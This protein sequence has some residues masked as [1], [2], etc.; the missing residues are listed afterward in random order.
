L[1]ITFGMT[2]VFP[3]HSTR[4][5]FNFCTL[6][7]EAARSPETLVINLWSQTVSKPTVPS[8]TLRCLLLQVQECWNFC[9]NS[10]K[11]HMPEIMVTWRRESLAVTDTA[12][13]S[14]VDKGWCHRLLG[15]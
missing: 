13:V 1:L 11:C 6:M 12:V 8:P 7:M 4:S 2:H 3:Y 14:S 5:R 10:R 9:I 15:F